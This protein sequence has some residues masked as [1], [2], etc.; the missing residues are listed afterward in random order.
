MSIDIV[1]LGYEQRS[2]MHLATRS[3]K[4]VVLLNSLF[5]SYYP[6]LVLLPCIHSRLK[7]ISQ[8]KFKNQWTSAICHRINIAISVTKK[9]S[10]FF[11]CLSGNGLI[12]LNTWRKNTNNILE[13]T[14][15]Y[16]VNESC[17]LLL[18]DGLV[19]FKA[20]HRLLWKI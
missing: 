12:I 7:V 11:L 20:A 17:R 3:S 18:S 9:K 19:I 15:V 14:R 16:W 2:E 13:H 10:D 4:E 8:E 1:I 6:L 5:L